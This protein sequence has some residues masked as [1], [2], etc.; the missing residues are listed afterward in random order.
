MRSFL[1]VVEKNNHLKVKE[2]VFDLSNWI[3][4]GVCVRDGSYG[5]VT[6]DRMIK[7]KHM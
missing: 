7:K 2:Q 5:R 1:D 4:M 3:V 6:I